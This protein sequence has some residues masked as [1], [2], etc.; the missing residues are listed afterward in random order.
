MDGK[1]LMRASAVGGLSLSVMLD[2]SSAVLFL[3]GV[4]T[5]LCQCMV[6]V[7]VEWEDG[8]NHRKAWVM[9]HT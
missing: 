5:L 3:R 7:R 8:S 4:S 1:W 9:S 2:R 6:L